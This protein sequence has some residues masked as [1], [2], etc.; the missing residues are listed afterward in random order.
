MV[1][2]LRVPFGVGS[3]WV[4]EGGLN[5]HVNQIRM[6]DCVKR[7]ELVFTVEVPRI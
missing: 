6:T 4:P 7:Q 5:Q 1:M 2:N 3:D